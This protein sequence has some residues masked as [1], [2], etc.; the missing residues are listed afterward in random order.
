MSENIQTL[1]NRLIFKINIF[2]ESSYNDRVANNMS[3]LNNLIIK[4]IDINNELFRLVP[5]S[6][7]IRTSRANLLQ[8]ADHT[9]ENENSELKNA[10]IKKYREIFIGKNI[11]NEIVIII[12]ELSDKDEF[13]FSEPSNLSPN[14]RQFFGRR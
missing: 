6:E 9:I 8:L 5:E 3:A 13:I 12:D 11:V 7:K 10:I 14:I 2:M 4:I 1:H